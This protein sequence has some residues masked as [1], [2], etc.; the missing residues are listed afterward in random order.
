MRDVRTIVR[1]FLFVA[2]FALACSLGRSAK[3]DDPGYVPDGPNF[4]TITL[5]EGPSGAFG[6]DLQDPPAPGAWDKE[7][8]WNMQV[9]GYNDNQ[10]RPIYQPLVVNENGREILYLGNLPGNLMNPLTGNVEP[11]G[12]SI[13]DVTDV[14]HPKFLYHIPGPSGPIAEAGV[15]MVEMQRRRSA[16]CCEGQMVFAS[17]IWKRWPR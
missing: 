4:P 5:N 14:A 16:S 11:N 15:Q 13:V 8:I 7:S 12:T 6:Q 10:G 17:S 2:S 1:G 9:V 3:A